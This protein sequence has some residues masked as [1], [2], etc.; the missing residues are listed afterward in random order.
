MSSGFVSAGTAD[1]NDTEEPK[2][3]D[4][5][6]KAR[7]ELEE[8]RKA[9]ETAGIQEGG[10]SLFEVLQANKGRTSR[11]FPS[12]NLIELHSM[13]DGANMSVLFPSP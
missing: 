13:N 8:S 6:E 7:L 12:S 3:T 2:D 10:K 1:L 4:E 11:L 5:W 9:K